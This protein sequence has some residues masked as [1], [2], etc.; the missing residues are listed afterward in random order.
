MKITPKIYAQAYWTAATSVPQNKLSKIA[1]NFWRVVWRHGH[2]KW[3]R[4]IMEELRVLVR[5]KSGLKLVTVAVPR[6][7]TAEQRQNFIDKLQQALKSG[8]ELAYLVKPHLLGGLV[9]TVEDERYDASLKGR[10]EALCRRL[11]DEYD[12]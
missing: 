1:E 3:R 5:Q 6:E 7:M 8:V 12:S 11:A 10:L 4:Q 2:F 9:L